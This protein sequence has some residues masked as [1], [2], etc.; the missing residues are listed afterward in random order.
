[1]AYIVAAV[2]TAGGKRGGKL[3]GWHPTDLGAAVLDSLVSKTRIDPAL[4]DDVILGC[5]DQAGQTISPSLPKPCIK[6]HHFLF[7][8]RRTI[9]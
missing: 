7:F 5:V 2:R 4:I 6:S 3:S 8:P 1:M 9:I